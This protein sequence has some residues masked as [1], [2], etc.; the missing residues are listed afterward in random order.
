LASKIGGILAKCG[1]NIKFKTDRIYVDKNT[2]KNS[3]LSV[4]VL[5][6]RVSDHSPIELSIHN[7]NLY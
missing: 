1:I 4:K 2:A 5:P 6:N 7:E 3:T